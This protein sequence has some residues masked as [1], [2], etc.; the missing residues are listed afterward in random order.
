[1]RRADNAADLVASLHLLI[2][3][4]QDV[5]RGPITSAIGFFEEL[6]PALVERLVGPEQPRRRVLLA[7]GAGD[8]SRRVEKGVVL[9]A[10]LRAEP[11]V[12][13]LADP[14][15]STQQDPAFAENV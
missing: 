3:L 8:A 15:N 13:A 6:L 5:R 4:G 1:M 7:D 11:A 14:V 12:E 10:A 9:L 2:D